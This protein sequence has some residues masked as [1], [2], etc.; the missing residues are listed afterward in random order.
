MLILQDVPGSDAQVVS[1]HTHGIP[2]GPLNGSTDEVVGWCE[3]RDYTVTPDIDPVLGD[4]LRVT[5]PTEQDAAHFKM[6]WL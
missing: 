2:I 4:T 3:D 6:R 1:S 5:L